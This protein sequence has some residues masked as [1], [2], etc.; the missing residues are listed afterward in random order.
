MPTPP[1]EL[2]AIEEEF[3]RVKLC[4][5]SSVDESVLEE[6]VQEVLQETLSSGELVE[7]RDILLSA[8]EDIV[9]GL[10]KG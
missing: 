1:L 8:D 3:H 6:V 4:S 9:E 10:W 7:G 5:V 2:D